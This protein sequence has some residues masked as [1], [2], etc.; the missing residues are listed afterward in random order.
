MNVDS[1][2]FSRK[3]ETK[4]KKTKNKKKHTHTDP[5]PNC[6]RKAGESSI[7]LFLLMDS[8]HHT[9]PPC[10]RFSQ[11]YPSFWILLWGLC[12]PQQS[13]L[14]S[15]LRPRRTLLLSP[16]PLPSQAQRRQC[17]RRS[18]WGPD[19]FLLPRP[20]HRLSFPELPWWPH[21]SPLP[22]CRTCSAVSVGGPCCC[23]IK[24]I[25]RAEFSDSVTP[26]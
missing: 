10:I 16:A 12:W 5:S 15:L 22:T 25:S 20:R 3:K 13:R 6:V 1:R 24:N 4:R 11:T 26:Y 17:W 8:E 18:W 2:V 7:A 14:R 21:T 9:P 19:S 23:L